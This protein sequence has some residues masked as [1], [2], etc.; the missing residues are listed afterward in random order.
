VRDVLG[1]L[2]DLVPPREG[3][4]RPMHVNE[5]LVVL[6]QLEAILQG[7]KITKLPRRRGQRHSRVR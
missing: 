7:E 2:A 5:C 6:R 4:E 3:E 1:G